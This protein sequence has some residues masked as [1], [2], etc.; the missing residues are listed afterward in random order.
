MA[1]PGLTVAFITAVDLVL[2]NEK[3]IGVFSQWQALSNLMADHAVSYQAKD[4]DCK[5]FL[6]HPDNRG[7]LGLNA[8]N[9]HRNG[10]VIAKVGA[11][12]SELTN[13]VAFELSS[14]ASK[15]QEQVEFNQTLV[16]GAN[17]LLAPVNHRE[18]FITVGCS[19]VTA[20]TK[21]ALAGCKT[22]QKDL[23]D[24]DGRINS[25]HLAEHDPVLKHMFEKGWNWTIIPAMVEEQ[26][27]CLPQL[28]QQALNSSSNV[29][30]STS[31]LETA[32]TIAEYAELSRRAGQ[33]IDWEAC[34]T[35]AAASSPPCKGYIHVLA[36]YVKL[37][38]GGDGAPM[39]KYL[40]QF[41]KS[42][43]ENLKLGEEYIT[44]VTEAKLAGGTSM[45]PHVRTALMATNLTSPKVT[46]GISR[47]L[48]ITDIVKLKNKAMK[49]KITA[50]EE[51]LAE[52][53]GLLHKH[54]GYLAS[55]RKLTV[56]VIL[57]L[58]NKGKQGAEKVDYGSLADIRAAFDEETGSGPTA[59][60]S[61]S[62]ACENGPLTFENVSCP[63]WLAGQSGYMVGSKYVAKGYDNLF[64]LTKFTGD[65][66]GNV[67]FTEQNMGFGQ[68]LVVT[69][70]IAELSNMALWKG[71]HLP[72][73]LPSQMSGFLAYTSQ[74]TEDESFKAR[75]FLA[76]SE[77]TK[78]HGPLEAWLAFSIHPSEVRARRAFKKGELKLVPSTDSTSKVS[79]VANGGVEVRAHPKGSGYI[80][81]PAPCN[82]TTELADW[83]KTT[84]LA[85]HW[86]VL[87][88]SE[89]ADANMVLQTLNQDGISIPCLTNSRPLKI[90]E[91][92][93]K[94]QPKREASSV[95]LSK[96]QA[97]PVKKT[98]K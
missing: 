96:L 10:S 73:A 42:C 17:G 75:C 87:N 79:L 3:K 6:C 84:V 58:C 46:D 27:P 31:E 19:H 47:L 44:A 68:A 93:Q 48:T 1:G 74:Q 69:V 9:A 81:G 21:A 94:F 22:P 39:V 20:F 83:S 53:H 36:K 92:L 77:L 88:T 61:S 97:S 16:E 24:A 78:V 91:K 57:H 89:G 5:L 30:S 59:A 70:K 41:S 65:A 67:I 4:Q 35:A 95:P 14:V 43:G 11:N 23:A 15:R 71:Q 66:D 76:L 38:G 26:W 33:V 37:Y 82:K 98:R 40:D 45:F 7:K 62:S 25:S 32:S 50:A 64:E 63:K 51:F 29:S 56:R 54:P 55:Y 86:W 13:S 85:A 49:P 72:A 34:I 12:L 2:K 52:A 28:V 60:A 90:Y 18:R 8:Y 80:S